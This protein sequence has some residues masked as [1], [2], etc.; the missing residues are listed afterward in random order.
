MPIGQSSLR[1]QKF[2][3]SLRLPLVA[4]EVFVVEAFP[5]RCRFEVIMRIGAFP[6]SMLAGQMGIRGGCPGVVGRRGA[7]ACVVG[8][9][10][11][12]FAI[13]AKGH[14][15]ITAQRQ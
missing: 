14:P 7:D 8:L 11:R 5:W 9:R 13:E 10:N 4:A 15:R 2:G 3:A 12:L 1:D 6:C